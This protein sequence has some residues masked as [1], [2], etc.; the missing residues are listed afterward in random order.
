MPI[1]RLGK[2][3][4]I[5]PRSLFVGKSSHDGVISGGNA[6]LKQIISCNLLYRPFPV[7]HNYLVGS[8]NN[9]KNINFLFV[10]YCYISIQTFC[11][12]GT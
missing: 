6:I 11:N 1:G 4:Q 7:V 3:N 8:Q 10:C 2:V 9:E 5:L 12:E